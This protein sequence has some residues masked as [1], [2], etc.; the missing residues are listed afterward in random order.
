[1]STCRNLAPTELKP[2]YVSYIPYMVPY[3]VGL[4]LQERIVNRRALARSVLRQAGVP[5]HTVASNTPLPPLLEHERKI[6]LTDIL[7]LLQHTPVYTLGRRDDTA[8]VSTKNNSLKAD[9]FKTQRGGLLTYH[10]PGQL[11]GYPI[12]DLGVLGVSILASY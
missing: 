3:G 1:M 11:I 12:L 5:T 10:G 4:K 8:A 2:L 9:L 7:F 6:A